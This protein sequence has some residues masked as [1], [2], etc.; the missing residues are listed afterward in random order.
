MKYLYP[1]IVFTCCMMLPILSQSWVSSVAPSQNAIGVSPDASFSVTFN[2]AM[3]ASTLDVNSLIINGNLDGFYEAQQVQYDMASNTVTFAADKNFQ[4]GEKIRV[5][6]TG[7]VTDSS[8]SAMP[9]GFSWE[10]I[11]SPLPANSQFSSMPETINAGSQP[12]A[13]I[14]ARLDGAQSDLAIVN[15]AEATVDILILPEKQ[16]IQTINVGSNPESIAAGDFDKDGDMDLATANS[17]ASTISLLNNTNGVFTVSN[18]L[19]TGLSPHTIQSIDIDQD[20]D[21]DLIT[22]NFGNGRLSIFINDGNGQFSRD[23]DPL[24]DV[25]PELPLPIDADLDGDFDLAV[26]HF[27]SGNI[28]LLS[29]SGPAQFSASANISLGVSPHLAAAGDLNGDGFADILVPVSGSGQSRIVLGDGLGELAFGNALTQSGSPW[30]ATL[31]DFDGDGDLDAAIPSYNAGTLSIWLN[32][33]SGSFTLSANSP[34]AVGNKPHVVQH[35]DF[36]GDG[37]IDLAV[38]NEG[39]NSISLLLQTPAVAIEPDPPTADVY[40]ISQNYPNPFNPETRFAVILAEQATLKI[41]ISDISGRTVDQIAEQL[42]PAGEHI[43]P[44]R[45]PAEAGLLLASGVYFAQLTLTSPNGG[46]K[47][48]KTLK[49]VLSK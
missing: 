27:S 14:A 10:F 47:Y 37:T 5:T 35:G 39:S 42:Y 43:V 16:I 8:N 24:V 30:S 6:I 19:A 28:R 38:C 17:G 13:M 45:A 29:N 18:T 1:A 32:D 44:W 40:H 23:A 7:A 22:S 36:D 34:I 48:Q 9:G 26:A 20:G 15:K 33:G 11:I 21:I 12:Y 3:S 4:P 46:K 49:L 31:A 2:R 41:I 25:L